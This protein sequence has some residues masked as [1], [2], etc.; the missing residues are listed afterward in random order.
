MFGAVILELVALLL[1]YILQLCNASAHG[2]V[3]LTS[4]LPF[5]QRM[6]IEA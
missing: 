3:F 1:R 2:F 5:S 6:I 4:S